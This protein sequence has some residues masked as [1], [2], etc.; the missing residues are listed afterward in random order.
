VNRKAALPY[1]I[2]ALAIVAAVFCVYIV[3][4][5]SLRNGKSDSERYEM[6]KTQCEDFYMSEMERGV[7]FS[8]TPCDEAQLKQVFKSQYGYDYR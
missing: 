3:L 1:A 8:G 4:N 2:L 5:S 6:V 7:R